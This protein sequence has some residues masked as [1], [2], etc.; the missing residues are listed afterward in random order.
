[1]PIAPRHSR[2]QAPP[3]V[4]RRAVRG[5][6]ALALAIV[7]L[8]DPADA[9]TT[10]A[11]LRE[12]R[13]T[14]VSTS[15]LA[16]SGMSTPANTATNFARL[17]NVGLNSIYIDCFRNG[18]AY[19]NSPSLVAAG[20]SSTPL[21]SRDFLAEGVLQARR[22]QMAPFAWF[23]YGFMASFEGGNEN[24][25]GTT[26][27]TL[28]TNLARTAWN[29]GW[30]LQDSSG[31]VSTTSQGFTWMN[32][33]IPQVRQLLINM[34][35]EVVTNYNV[36]GIQFDDHTA[37]PV[38][39]GYDTTTRNL[40]AAENPGFS[41]PAS[42]NATG[43]T[44][45]RFN[46]WRTG[47]LTTFFTDLQAAIRAVRPSAILSISPSTMPTANSSF[48]A[49]WPTWVSSGLLDEYVPQVYRSGYTNFA[50]DWS[51]TGSQ[52]Q[53]FTP[54]NRMGDAVAGMAIDTSNTT[55][56]DVTQS[57]SLVRNTAG[58]AGHSIWYANGIYANEAAFTSFY[59]VAGPTGVGHAVR[60]D[61]PA[62]LAPI[63]GTSLGANQWRFILSST[64]GTFDLI[65]ADA[66]G[67]W[68]TSQSRL[69]LSSGTWTYTLPAGTTAVEL[70]P[71][72]LT[73]T[74]PEPG[75]VVLLAAPAV[76][77]LRRRNANA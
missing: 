76:M 35:V 66:A 65:Y 52:T 20:G 3:G 15:N 36:A 10:S 74:V 39:F 41:L 70:L 64:A 29:N 5:L 44:L 27:S 63:V 30:L 13:G 22:N 18:A 68:F 45:T 53:Y 1:M 11:H 56:A 16:A 48:L 72:R 26:G 47:K 17:R 51:G 19:F 54:S 25:T 6:L 55:V 38:N 60:P 50:R 59:N 40:F 43:S 58:A 62:L 21:G 9:Q 2:R 42:G 34:A 24:P 57:I 49:N 4:A 73:A 12:V 32:P 46:A 75:S 69:Q 71:Y 7:A 8:P 14:W 77:L 33:A 28:A 31:N 67:A 61:M 37:W 23:Q